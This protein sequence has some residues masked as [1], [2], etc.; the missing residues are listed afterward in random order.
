MKTSAI[1]RIILWSLVALVLVGVLL[2]S[3]AVD[4]FQFLIDFDS[5]ST[6]KVEDIGDGSTYRFDPDKIQEL[7]IEWVSGSVTV[8]R[9]DVDEI[10]VS[11]PAQSERWRMTCSVSGSKLRVRFRE[12]S[13]TNIFQ[14]GFRKNPV[15]GKNL[16]ITVPQDWSCR[17]LDLSSVS[18]QVKLLD[19]AVDSFDLENVSGRVLFQ[20]T[21]QEVECDTVSGGLTLECGNTPRS[22][23]FDSVSADLT[24]KLPAE[25]DG[26]RVDLD[27]VSGKFSSDFSTAL[28]NG[29]YVHAQGHCRIDA[30]SV[31][32]DVYIR[33]ND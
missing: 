33:S 4:A 13:F 30:D 6:Y 1:I 28:E 16:V 9:G 11:E 24:V 23:R 3:L 12:G 2:A 27:A 5:D 17:E 18:A 29:V 31:S 19:L 21:V 7:E 15:S 22:V 14:F 32:G 10:I 8:Q 26:F 25:N 20:G